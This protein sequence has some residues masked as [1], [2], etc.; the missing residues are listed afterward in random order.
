[1]MNR[2]RT[3]T[4]LAIALVAMSAV[5]W[6]AGSTLQV[7]GIQSADFPFTVSARYS[8]S[9][10]TL[11]VT[12]NGS[13]RLPSAAAGPCLGL[14]VNGQFIPNGDEGVVRLPGGGRAV[15]LGGWGGFQG[16]IKIRPATD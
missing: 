1:M 8:G 4:S 2:R 9:T 5:A 13:S 14:E 7:K 12:A 10:R 6:A 15:V 3:T 11:I 16:Q